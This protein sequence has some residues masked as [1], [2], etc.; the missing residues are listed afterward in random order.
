MKHVRVISKDTTL[1]Q[2]PN[3][4]RRKHDFSLKILHQTGFETARQA[5]TLTMLHA[6]PVVPR[7]SQYINENNFFFYF[8]NK[9]NL[10]QLWKDMHEKEKLCRNCKGDRNRKFILKN[11]FVQAQK[12]FDKSL[13]SA[14]I[15]YNRDTLE[16]IEKLNVIDPDA[17]WVHIKRMGS[18]SRDIPLNFNRDGMTTIN[19]PTVLENWKTEFDSLYNQTGQGNLDDQFYENAKSQKDELETN[20]YNNI[21]YESNYFLNDVISFNEVV[22]CKNNF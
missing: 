5:A 18:R 15:N 3:I 8:M 13:R 14:E 11:K 20:M 9:P 1:K 6:L 4:G 16:N 12:I 21:N 19:I 10:S 22:K 17:F 2:C 7:P